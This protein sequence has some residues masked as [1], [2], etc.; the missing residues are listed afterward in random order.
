[1]NVIISSVSGEKISEKKCRKK[2]ARKLGLPVRTVCRSHTI[3]TRILQSEKSSWTYTNIK[4]RSD[5]ITPDTKKRIYEFWCKPGI[6][7]PT[8]NKANIK[9]VR[10]GPKTYSSHMTHILE[11]N[12]DRYVFGF[13]RRK[14]LY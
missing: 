11:K 6:S 4:T 1:M 3:R 2:L 8:G 14:P 5:A 9:R 10:I 12:T 13:Y 7:R